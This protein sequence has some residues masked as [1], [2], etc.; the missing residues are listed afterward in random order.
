[1]EQG[2]GRGGQGCWGQEHDTAQPKWLNKSGTANGS[3]M[4]QRRR[5]EQDREG[6]GKAVHMSLS[7]QP[8]QCTPVQHS[9]VSGG[10]QLPRLPG[11]RWQR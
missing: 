6:A 10:A 2:K 8:L 1:M 5:R 3:P 7:P 9:P 4:Q 11:A